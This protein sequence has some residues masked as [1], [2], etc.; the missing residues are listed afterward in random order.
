MQ[1]A[2]LELCQLTSPDI[3]QCF[4]DQ[5]CFTKPSFYDAELAGCI[6]PG[7]PHRLVCTPVLQHP[8]K[9]CKKPQAG[10]NNLERH[11]HTSQKTLNPKPP[12]TSLRLPVAIASPI[13]ARTPCTPVVVTAVVIVVP[14]IRPSWRRWRHRPLPAAAQ[15]APPPPIAHSS[16]HA[17]AHFNFEPADVHRRILSLALS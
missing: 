11:T 8:S 12:R 7:V 17:T 3:W 2:E 9:L 1:T 16:Y 15:P 4:G 14:W 6:T 13:P 10:I 5:N